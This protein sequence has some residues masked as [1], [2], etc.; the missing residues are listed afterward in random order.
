MSTQNETGLAQEQPAKQDMKKE[1]QPKKQEANKEEQAA[2]QDTKKEEEPLP[3]T[4]DAQKLASLGVAAKTTKQLNKRV[5][6]GGA[7][8][9]VEINA[10]AEG[11]NIYYWGF[12]EDRD[13]PVRVATVSSTAGQK[14]TLTLEIPDPGFWP[15]ER[16]LVLA[17]FPIVSGEPTLKSPG[18]FVNQK[19]RVSTRW[20]SF[21]VAA[22]VVFFAYLI[23]VLALG[24]VGKSYSWNP[25][26]LTSDAFDKASLSQFQIFGFTL[27][28]LGLLV[29][30]LL[31]TGVLSDIST[32]MLLLLGISAAGTVGSKTA[33]VMKKR[34]SSENWS[35]LRNEGWLTVYEEGTGQAADAKRARWGDLLKINASFDIYSL[36]LAVFSLL[37]ALGILTSDLNKLS[38]FSV[39][40]NLLA[41]LGLSN[42]VYIG[43]KAITP[44][45]VSELDKKVEALRD[46]EKKWA[47]KVLKDV[48]AADEKD[49]VRKA[50]ETSPEEYLAYVTSARE[51]ARM[52][53]ALY[54]KQGTKFTTDPIK[55]EELMPDF[56]K[57][58]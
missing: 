13:S 32:D 55:D 16:N 5:L 6:P 4:M 40:P 28:V 11:S 1:E 23:S 36:Q 24:R 3:V 27:L 44:N 48:M 43:G 31:R 25:V 49:K 58:K 17:S 52:L 30:V 39:P 47:A 15:T 33:E 10:V 53:T 18:I 12:I 38:T 26:Y 57:T 9:T 7:V 35:W 2:K 41:L 14:T 42:V 50:V 8:A 22:A 34:L 20:L 56:L 51:A 45:S 37:V 19:V 21:L 54:G 29:F 46:A